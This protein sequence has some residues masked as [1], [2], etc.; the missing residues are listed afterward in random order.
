ME[1]V[2]IR[3]GLVPDKR[4]FNRSKEFQE[5]VKAMLTPD[6]SKLIEF[7]IVH[8]LC[9]R[10]CGFSAISLIL[11]ILQYLLIYMSLRPH[12]CQTFG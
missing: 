10:L 11:S 9:D 8:F 1:Y 2:S 3:F 5:V 4:F 6:A 7:Y 12:R